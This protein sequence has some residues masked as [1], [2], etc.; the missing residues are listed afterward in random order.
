MKATDEGAGPAPGGGAA[1]VLPEYEPELA[2]EAYGL[3]RRT[4]GR[5]FRVR[6]LDTDHIRRDGP[7]MVVGC[8]SGVIPYDAACTLAAIE[9]ATG[10]LGLGVGDRFFGQNPT[11]QRFLRR[12]GAVVGDR[13]TSVRLLDE[14]HLLLVFPGGALDMMRPYWRH[15]YRVLAHRGFAPGRG[16]YVKIA[17]R[18]G[19]PIV[20]LA[21]VGTEE[22]HVMLGNLPRVANLLRVPLVP[23]LAFGLPLPVAIFIRFGEPIEIGRDPDAAED[24]AHVDDLN[25]RVRTAVQDLIDDTRSRRRGIFR[26]G[27][28]S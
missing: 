3:V 23:V 6:A 1:G 18:T 10:R 17:L 26:G 13:E 20:P 12:R 27:W 19:S 5:Y 22:A 24:Q 9:E 28:A 15:P 11:L 25:R 21:V 8:H 14:G 16:G 7:C 2:H 4:V